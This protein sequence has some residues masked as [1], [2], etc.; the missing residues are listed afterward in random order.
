M[1]QRRVRSSRLPPLSRRGKPCL[2]AGGGDLFRVG[3]CV[4]TPGSKAKSREKSAFALRNRVNFRLNFLIA[5][6]FCQRVIT[7]L[8]FRDH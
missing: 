1:D 7:D 5:E 8:S 4:H 6:K 2:R 3:R